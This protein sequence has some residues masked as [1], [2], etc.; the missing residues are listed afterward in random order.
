[1]ACFSQYVCKHCGFEIM[2]EPHFYYRI[3]FGYMITRKC[4]ACKCIIHEPFDDNI[5]PYFE[6]TRSFFQ[7]IET[8]DF[9]NKS[10]VC[11]DCHQS[12]KFTLWSPTTNR[13]PKCNHKMTLIRKNIM[14]VD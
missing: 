2:T 4:S 11:P 13:C 9:R 14:M 8:D 7:W 5:I 12:A 6:D 1:M 10:G 3:K